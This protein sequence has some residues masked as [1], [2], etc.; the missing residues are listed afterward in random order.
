MRSIR[1]S[2]AGA[3]TRRPTSTSCACR[4][5]GA[6]CIKALGKLDALH[7]L[8]FDEIHAKGDS[9]YVQGD[10][11]GTL[12]LDLQF[13]RANGIDGA[14]F[15]KAYNSFAVE[16]DLEKADDLVR[17]YKID[18][19]PTFIIDG[20]YETDVAQAGGQEK[21]I[22]LINDLAASEKQH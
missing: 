16:T 10:E 11:Q 14:E 7:T 15:L 3:R 13:A 19:V 4:S 22:Q 12:R 1:S 6:K 9:L 17:R 18:A 8:V 21:L 20:K 2:R 5:P